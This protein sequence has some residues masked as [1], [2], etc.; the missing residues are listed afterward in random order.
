MHPLRNEA[1]FYNEELLVPRPTPKLEDHPMSAVPDCSSGIFVA[2][3]HIRGRPSIRAMPR[4]QGPVYRM[5]PTH[6]VTCVHFVSKF[7]KLLRSINSS[8]FLVILYLK[9]N[10]PSSS[11]FYCK[12]DQHKY[13]ANLYQKVLPMYQKKWKV[14]IRQRC[15]AVS[16]LIT[17]SLKKR[18]FYGFYSI[19]INMKQCISTNNKLI[20][21]KS[22]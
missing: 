4:W 2:T 20:F 18:E 12:R 8:R 3:I 19:W 7:W 16:S 6:Y 5:R 13:K 11:K 22:K 21:W 14:K 10:C 1:G 9:K 15:M 17:P